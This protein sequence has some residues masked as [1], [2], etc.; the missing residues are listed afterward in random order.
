[1]FKCLESRLCYMMR[2]VI[3]YTA[4]SW[5]VVVSANKYNVEYEDGEFQALL[6]CELRRICYLRATES[7]VGINASA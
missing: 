1:M 6:E 3:P 5:L 2:V 7:L 4:S